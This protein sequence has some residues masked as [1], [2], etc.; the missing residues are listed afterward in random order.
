MFFSFELQLILQGSAASLQIW[1]AS[2]NQ[3]LSFSLIQPEY[4]HL[5]PLQR[6][7]TEASHVKSS[8]YRPES[9]ASH[10]QPL[11]FGPGLSASHQQQPM[12]RPG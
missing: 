1:P 5:M 9:A 2:S 6:V 8:H 7:G 12:F 11:V 4:C 10:Q 3:I